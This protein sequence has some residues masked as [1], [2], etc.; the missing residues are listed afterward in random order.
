MSK[1]RGKHNKFDEGKRR[2]EE[3][4]REGKEWERG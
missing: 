2:R 3:R 4:V 1:R